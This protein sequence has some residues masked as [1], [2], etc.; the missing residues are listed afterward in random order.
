MTEEWRNEEGMGKSGSNGRGV[1]REEGR[2][3]FNLCW[4]SE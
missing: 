1:G 3:L 2:G 4:V